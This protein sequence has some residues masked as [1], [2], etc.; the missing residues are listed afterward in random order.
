MSRDVTIIKNT[1][2][3]ITRVRFT[4]NSAFGSGDNNSGGHGGAVLVSGINVILSFCTFVG[5]FAR[6]DGMFTESPSAGG[7]LYVTEMATTRVNHCTFQKNYVD[8]GRAGAIFATDSNKLLL[9]NS[10]FWNNYVT[11]TYNFKSSGGAVSIA[12][13]GKLCVTIQYSIQS[14]TITYEKWLFCVFL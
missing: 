9:H 13:R 11:S 2:L 7:A 6:S 14:L 10:S 4:N 1:D 5:N 12:Q 3:K 8:G